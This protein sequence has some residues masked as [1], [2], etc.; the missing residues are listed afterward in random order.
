M[1]EV[2]SSDAQPSATDR[3]ALANRLELP[4]M[5]APSASAR[6]IRSGGAL[7]H[8]QK[9]I[10]PSPASGGPSGGLSCPN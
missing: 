5:P 1:D 2:A 4:A 8:G 6:P 7:S 10:D 9:V 3:K